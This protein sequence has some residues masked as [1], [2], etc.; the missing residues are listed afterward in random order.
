MRRGKMLVRLCYL[1]VGMALLLLVGCGADCEL[2]ATARTWV[3]Q[4]ENGVWD[5]DESPLSGV[6]CF[7]DSPYGVGI[8]EAVSDRNGEARLYV[9]LADCPKRAVYS[10]YV[11]SPVGYRPTTQTRL[12]GRQ[13]VEAPFVFGF[14]RINE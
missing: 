14:A 8:G 1:T 13:P 2:S 7:I 10:V 9:M 4:N 6:G 3:D 11:D 12:P 5:T